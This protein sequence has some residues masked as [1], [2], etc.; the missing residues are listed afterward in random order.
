MTS[1]DASCMATALSY[2]V[3]LSAV[4][5]FDLSVIT[6]GSESWTVTN[7]MEKKLD[8]CEN[9]WLRRI[10]L[11]HSTGQLQREDYE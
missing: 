8:A 7:E 4:G 6:Y 2:N 10:L 1:F 3:A 9:G 5:L 11:V